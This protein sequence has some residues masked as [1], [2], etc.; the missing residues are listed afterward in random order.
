VT[1][2]TLFHIGSVSKTMSAAAVMQLV[3]QGR[4]RLDA[5]L[6]R[7]VPGFSLRPR[8][9][10][11]VIT[12]RSVLDH[13]SG[14]PGDMFN[15]LF[16]ANKPDPGY[17]TS[18]LRALRGQCPERPVNTAWAYNNS[19][20]VLL[21]NVVEHVTGEAFDAYTRTNLFRPMR[22]PSTTFDDAHVPAARLTRSYEAVADKHALRVSGLPREY[23]NGWAAGSVVSSARDMSAYLKT[24]I[25]GGAVQGRRVLGAPT[26]RQMIT[27][28]TDLPLDIAPFRMGLGWWVGDSANSWMGTVIHHAGHT[29]SNDTEVMWLPRSKLG[30]FVSVNTHS[31]VAV[32]HEVAVLA[33]G[34]MVTDKTG[35]RAPSAPSVSPMVHVPAQTLRRAAGIY[36]SN[37]GIDL[38]RAAGG[39]LLWTPEAQKPNA[40]AAVM[41][42]RAD[43]WYTDAAASRSIK[44][45]TVAGRQLSLGRTADGAIGTIAQRIPRSYPVSSSWRGRT[46][47]YRALDVRPHTYPGAIARAGRLTIDDGVLLWRAT[48]RTATR[49]TAVLVPAGRH[50]AF[51][52]GPASF[53]VEAGAGDGVIAGAK[54]LS[55]LG[56]TYRK[57]GA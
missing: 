29:V 50:L 1:K 26:L 57:T 44:T 10:N 20:Y 38:V 37:R 51:T 12:V 19:G 21:Q 41:T 39:A 52:F 7:Y 2:D 30:V 25:A 16:T 24:M 55:I 35:R 48:T 4:V 42:P 46:G 27:P 15:G 14:I 28:Q 36:A 49:A 22:M 47:R 18:L 23:V 11:S 5:P 43:G 13:H 3:Q 33:L 9:P 17:R 56:V 53:N 54:T 6:A 8:F 32:E 40:A 45:V 34:L 31:P